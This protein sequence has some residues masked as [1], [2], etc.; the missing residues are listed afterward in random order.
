MK[1]AGCFRVR[2][3]KHGRLEDGPSGPMRE[4][5]CIYVFIYQNKIIYVGETTKG[6]N[7]IRKGLKLPLR[8]RNRL[9]YKW[10][11]RY[12][13]KNLAIVLFELPKRKFAGQNSQ[14]SQQWRRALEAEI[15]FKLRRRYGQWPK[16]MTEIHFNEKLRKR[17]LV[18]NELRSFSRS[19][20]KCTSTKI[21]PR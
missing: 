7:R 20:R 4:I 3:G 15:V 9:A 14:E 21:R 19:I 1:K 17:K 13:R 5:V 16:A 18:Q 2:L 6:F 12:P 10:R 11:K 8:R